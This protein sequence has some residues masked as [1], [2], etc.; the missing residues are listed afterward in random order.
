MHFNKNSKRFNF[1]MDILSGCKWNCA[2]CLIDRTTNF[3]FPKQDSLNF[4]KLVKSFQDTPYIPSIFMLGPTDFFTARNIQVLLE[5]EIVIEIINSF[6]RLTLNSTFQEVNFSIIDSINDKLSGVEIE[7]RIVLDVRFIKDNDY[8]MKIQKNYLDTVKRL[9][10]K[11]SI[12]CHPQINLFD[13]SS[14]ILKEAMG[15]YKYLNDRAYEYFDQGVDYAFSFSREATFPKSKIFKVLDFIKDRF[16]FHVNFESSKNGIH[17]DSSNLKDLSEFLLSYR[18]GSL[19][20]A[21]GI[22]DEYVSFK[23]FYKIPIKEWNISELINYKQE[24]IIEMLK[25]V[26]DKPCSDCQYVNKCVDKG[27]IYFM[28]EIDHPDCI[29]PLISLD[30]VNRSSS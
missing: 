3:S 7:F 17:F 20:F 1:T 5:D 16:N 29:F 2:G 9:K 14:P 25:Y 28:K 18:S 8:M 23:D 4:L 22:Y 27:A 26:S 21:P 11:K 10:T 13:T 30:A 12:V 6:E 15:N 24:K 19:Y